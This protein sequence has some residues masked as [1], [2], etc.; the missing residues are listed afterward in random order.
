MLGAITGDIIGSAYERYPIK[1]KKFKLFSKHSQFTDDTVMTLAVV[2]AILEDEDYLKHVVYFG[3][4][5]A[6]VGYGA[7]FRKWL[8]SWN[9]KPYNSWGNGSAMRV[10]AIGFLSDTES[11]VLL[12]AKKSAEITHN[13]PE[14]IKG[15]EATALAIFM[16]RKG[17]SKNQIRER[18]SKQFDYDLNRTVDEIR[19]N[20]KFQVSC[21]ESV[22]E[23]IICF[24]DADSYEDTIRNAISLGGDA[25]TMACISGGI[26]EAYYGEIPLEILVEVYKRLP[27]EFLEIVLRFR[28]RV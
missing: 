25:D 27:K 26:A 19:P 13:H 20:Y 2:K 4:R 24:L 14:G 15:A 12:E 18:I 11:E 23:S 22:P 1:T 7:S 28:D 17:K 16:A 10:S 9:H 3:T 21:Q 6:D 8:Q 5:Y